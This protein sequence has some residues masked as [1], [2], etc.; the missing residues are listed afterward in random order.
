MA[1]LFRSRA[2]HAAALLMVVFFLQCLETCN[3]FWT[4]VEEE[5]AANTERKA[6]EVPVEYGVDVVRFV[7]VMNRCVLLLSLAVLK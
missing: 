1:P 3:A 4:A 7:F 6:A 5:D 2:A